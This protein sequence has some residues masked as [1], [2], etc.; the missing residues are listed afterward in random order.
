M[1][2]F[3][4][5]KNVDLRVAEILEVDEHPNADKLYV[6]RIKVGDEERNLVAGI[7]E[8]Y[9]KEELIGKKIIIVANLEPAVLRGVKSNGMLLAA[10]DDEGV[11]LLTVDRDVKDGSKIN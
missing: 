11:S 2:K 4:E 5:F 10:S 1:I 9:G 7:K 3:E 8:A 6:L